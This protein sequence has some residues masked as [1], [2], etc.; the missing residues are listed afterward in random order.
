MPNPAA[1]PP[2]SPRGDDDK[3]KPP[4]WRYL[5]VAILAVVGFFFIVTPGPHAAWG[6]VMLIYVL[7]TVLFGGRPQLPSQPLGQFLEI[8]AKTSTATSRPDDIEVEERS[9]GG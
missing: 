1:S 7:L 2:V 6:Y 8:F 3:H 9:D 4:F 5:F